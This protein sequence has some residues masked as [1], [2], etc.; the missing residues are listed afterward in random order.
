MSICHHNQTEINCPTCKKLHSSNNLK[1][2]PTQEQNK[3]KKDTN[4]STIKSY[5]FQQILLSFILGA[6]SSI[7]FIGFIGWDKF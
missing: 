4:K 7:V 6:A 3:I 1:D 5:N 2:R